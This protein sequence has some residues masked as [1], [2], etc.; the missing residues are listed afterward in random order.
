VSKYIR[1][2][3]STAFKMTKM[4]SLCGHCTYSHGK[5]RIKISIQTFKHEYQQQERLGSR[6]YYN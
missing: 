6:S 3:M 2:S 1:S 4:S 5:E